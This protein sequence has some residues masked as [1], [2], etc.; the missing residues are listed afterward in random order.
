MK[1]RIVLGM[2]IIMLALPFVGA[3]GVPDRGYHTM[4][5]SSCGGCP[6]QD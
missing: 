2:L 4:P 3:M 5:N 1:R 6:R